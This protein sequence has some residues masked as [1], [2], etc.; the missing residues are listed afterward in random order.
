MN[1][2][3]NITC[4]VVETILIILYTLLDNHKWN[5]I[6]ICLKGYDCFNKK[7]YNLSDSTNIRTTLSNISHPFVWRLSALNILQ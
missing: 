2:T 4:L 5:K 3:A 7:L 1:K 6:C